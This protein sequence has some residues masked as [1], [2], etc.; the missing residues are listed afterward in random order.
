MPDLNQR[1]ASRQVRILVVDLADGILPGVVLALGQGLEAE[2]LGVLALRV[3]HLNLR[4]HHKLVVRNLSLIVGVNVTCEPDLVDVGGYPT[5]RD[6][7][8][9]CGDVLDFEAF[10]GILL[11]V[12]L[13]LQPPRRLIEP[14]CL[15][16][17]CAGL[18]PSQ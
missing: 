8:T 11:K 16:D 1:G 10:D 6:T 3:K 12:P 14:G 13:D 18:L 7:H 15:P 5:R 17:D 9:V 2:I 4:C